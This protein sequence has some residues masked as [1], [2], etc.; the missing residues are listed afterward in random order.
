M[1]CQEVERRLPDYGV[2][3]LR[4]REEEAIASHLRACAACRS[5]WQALE[6]VVSLV[7]EFGALEPPPGLWNGV[8]NRI[9]ED[10][11]ERVAP[12]LWR[13]LWTRPVRWAGSAV[14]TAAILT[15][16]WLTVNPLGLH[17]LPPN[18]ADHALTAAMGEHAIASADGLFADRAGLESLA[19]LA[20][21]A[22]PR[23]TP[24]LP[25]DEPGL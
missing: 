23:A 12:S 4:P 1:Q 5:E 17:G 24:R 16:V 10:A 21:Q 3:L 9:V 18:E 14:A 25:V 2:G 13:R 22:S 8:Y 15:T 20:G 6:R 11:P 19:V 7:E